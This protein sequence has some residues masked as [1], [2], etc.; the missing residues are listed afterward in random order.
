[1]R[2]RQRRYVITYWRP[3]VALEALRED[4]PLHEVRPNGKLT[5]YP[6]DVVFVC[7]VVRRRRE[8]LLL[9]RLAVDRVNQL[10]PNRQYLYAQPP[11]SHLK[12]I[13]LKNIAPHLRFVTSVN[14]KW[15][16]IGED[17]WVD[18]LQFCAPRRITPESASLL[19]AMWA[20]TPNLS[21]LAV[22]REDLIGHLQHE[23]EY[24]AA[25]NGASEEIVCGA[26][27]GDPETNREV[28]QSAVAYVRGLYEDDG[29]Q[30][31][32][33]E[34]EKMGF[35][36]LCRR[37]LASGEEE[38]AHAEV[39]GIQSTVESFE[40]TA[41]EIDR[42]RNDPFFFLWVVT[43]ALSDEPRAVVYTPEEF[44]DVFRAEPSTYRVTRI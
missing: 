39:K 25:E 43:N 17:G 30:V 13:D 27:Y 44:R 5:V 29:F 12:C 37:R 3:E 21:N 19:E 41:R 1:M 33:Y 32:S 28:E 18:P 34:R 31:I 7:T 22:E 23:V 26:G 40:M 42:A 24:E 9:G 35:D 2:R 14:R 10:A 4:E 16:E 36:L 20:A 8:L 6:G 15:L 38:I 11:P